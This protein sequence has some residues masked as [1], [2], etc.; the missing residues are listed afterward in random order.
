MAN[1]RIGNSD[2]GHSDTGR[3][4]TGNPGTGRSVAGGSALYAFEGHAP[5]LHPTAWIAPT[6]MCM[7]PAIRIFISIRGAY[8]K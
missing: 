4:G 5:V 8:C 1:N 6:A 7:P 2:T 3:T